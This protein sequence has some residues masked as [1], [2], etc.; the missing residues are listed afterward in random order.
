[1]P[2]QRFL[3]RPPPLGTPSAAQR[4]AHADLLLLQ[5]QRPLLRTLHE[6]LELCRA[7]G[8]SVQECHHK[9][10]SIFFCTQVCVRLALTSPDFWASA[11][12]GSVCRTSCGGAASV[13]I[14]W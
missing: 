14:A 11:P 9:L 1:M 6:F 10:A 2:Y 3:R 13:I 5:E 12:I 4:A 7:Q 8:C